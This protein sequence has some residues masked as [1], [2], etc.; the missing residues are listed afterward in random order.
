MFV[1]ENIAKH[2]KK[3]K[4]LEIIIIITLGVERA[5]KTLIIIT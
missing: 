1:G 4:K 5:H 2:K 3:H